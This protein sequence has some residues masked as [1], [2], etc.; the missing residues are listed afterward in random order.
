MSMLA[1]AIVGSTRLER[2]IVPAP[3]WCAGLGW[4]VGRA[5]RLAIKIVLD[6]AI[7][8]VLAL[9]FWYARAGAVDT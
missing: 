9:D 5:R 7:R 3:C 1:R 2:A 8:P 4:L 6:G